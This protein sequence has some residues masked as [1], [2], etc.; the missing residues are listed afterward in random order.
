MTT[1][2]EFEQGLADLKAA[3]V[4]VFRLKCAMAHEAIG[5]GK[6]A[7]NAAAEYWFYSKRSIPKL[8]AV[9]RLMTERGLDIP[10]D[11]SLGMVWI[12]M[13][14]ADDDGVID[15]ALLGTLVDEGIRS[16]WS[17]KEAR[18]EWAKRG[19]CEEPPERDSY[20]DLGEGVLV[21]IG[22]K[23]VIELESEPDIRGK[24]LVKGKV[25]R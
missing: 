21:E 7:I 25:E 6:G 24:V 17:P 20:E 2:D 9:H 22:G 14:C 12:A 15:I 8:A 11:V 10:P 5:G 3:E 13:G 1:F 4:E 23:P 18:I 16:G 19:L